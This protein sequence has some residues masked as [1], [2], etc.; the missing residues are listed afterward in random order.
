[1]D[2][3]ADFEDFFRPIRNYFYWEP[4]CFDIPICWSIRSIFDVLDGVDGLTDKLQ[5]LTA[6]LDQMDVIMPQLLAQ[7]PEMIAIMT[8]MRGMLLTMH[9]T[10]SGV[11]GQMDGNGT[12]STAMG[13][14][15]DAAQNDDSFYIPPEVFKNEDFKRVM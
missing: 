6:N 2:H 4:H 3:I 11:L 8:S 7:F 13:K 9:S 12:N 5:Q 15:F 1:R 14:A 10:M